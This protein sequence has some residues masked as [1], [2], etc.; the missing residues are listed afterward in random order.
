MLPPGGLCLGRLN[1]LFATRRKSASAAVAKTGRAAL[2]SIGQMSV[3]AFGT[4]LAT[5]HRKHLQIAT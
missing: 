1:S 5:I 4:L 2:E 3:A